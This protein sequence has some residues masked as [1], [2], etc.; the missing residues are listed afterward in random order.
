MK[1]IV[2][3][4]SHGSMI[5]SYDDKNVTVTV[6]DKRFELDILSLWDLAKSAVLD[7]TDTSEGMRRRRKEA[8]AAVHESV[9]AIHA[10]QA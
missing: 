9:K 5:V 3:Q 6:G 4:N 1:T 8:I 7:S 2:A 10:A